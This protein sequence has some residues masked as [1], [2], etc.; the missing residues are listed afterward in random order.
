[1]DISQSSL[2]GDSRNLI[3]SARKINDL[4]E[5]TDN[6]SFTR[7]QMI[8]DFAREQMLLMF[9]HKIPLVILIR[10][11]ISSEKVIKMKIYFP[12]LEQIVIA[13]QATLT[14]IYYELEGKYTQT[15]KLGKMLQD[16]EIIPKDTKHII[17]DSSIVK[18]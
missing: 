8:A 13:N 11:K 17:C 18:I 3:Y 16:L 6:Q 9:E 2:I 15:K 4:R 10:R 5:E 12:N 1:M 14:G 7:D